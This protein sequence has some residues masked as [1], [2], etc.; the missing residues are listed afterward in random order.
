VSGA[1]RLCVASTGLLTI[2][3][4]PVVG[5]MAALSL[6][7]QFPAKFIAALPSSDVAVLLGGATRG[8][9]GSRLEVELGTAGNRVLHAARLYRAGKVRKILISAGGLSWSGTAPAEAD[10]IATLL[11]ELGVPEIDL[12]LERQSRTTIENAEQSKRVWVEQRFASGL[13]VTSALHMPRALALFQQAGMDLVPAT[14]D[15]TVTRPIIGGPLDLIPNAS[16]LVLFG[17]ALHEWTA[18]AFTRISRL[19]RTQ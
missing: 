15:V 6:E 3:A 18:I 7:G 19:I 2:A 14:T 1:Y 5:K 8:V 12:L 4:L 17:N 13:L 10:A 9:A 16:S 11:M